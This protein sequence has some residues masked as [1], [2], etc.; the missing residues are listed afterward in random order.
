[1]HVARGR[2]VGLGDLGGE[3][4]D[5]RGRDIS[6]GDGLFTQRIHVVALG[7]GGIGDLVAGQRRHDAHGRLRARQ[8]D[9]EIEH[10][11]QPRAIIEHSAHGR[12]RDQRGQQRGGGK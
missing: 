5:Q 10:L 3:R 6:G 1:M 12:A 9:D 8:R 2:G 11:L 7:L 4:I